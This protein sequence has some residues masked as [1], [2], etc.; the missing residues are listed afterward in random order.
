V[1]CDVAEVLAVGVAVNNAAVA[2]AFVGIN[3]GKVVAEDKG[4]AVAVT[5][6]A[7]VGVAM[8]GTTG[9]V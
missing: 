3:I 2:G 6:T 4:R 9:A 7:L 8:G 5:R 1:D